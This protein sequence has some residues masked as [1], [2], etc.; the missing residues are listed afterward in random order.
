MQ[1]NKK[2]SLKEELHHRLWPFETGLSISNIYCYLLPDRKTSG[3]PCSRVSPLYVNWEQP[4]HFQT[5][6]ADGGCKG[7]A[8]TI[9][10]EQHL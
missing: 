1:I 10:E 7:F 8:L 3:E 4:L 6:P 2:T 5:G 9:A